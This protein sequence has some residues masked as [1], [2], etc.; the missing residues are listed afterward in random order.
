GEA[1]AGAAIFARDG[2]I[3]LHEILEKHLLLVGRHT[4]AGVGNL[5]YDPILIFSL[6]R[7]V[8]SD[9]SVICELAGVAQEVEQDL[10]NLRDIRMHRPEV[11][12]YM[13]LYTVRS[14]FEG[15]L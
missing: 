11:F 2:C 14:L 12:G 13:N 15:R 9:G 6:A 4:D 8:Q 10:A 5:E 7:Y 1:Q 3:G